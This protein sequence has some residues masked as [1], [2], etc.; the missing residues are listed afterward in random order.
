M[1]NEN[2]S[3][4]LTHV[5]SCLRDN[6]NHIQSSIGNSGDLIVKELL[7]MQKWPAAVFYIDGL[8]NTQLLHDSVLRS[9]M[10]M[11]TAESLTRSELP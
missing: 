5:S 7:W 1:Q 6:V 11:D 9:F 4:P 8:I 2:K 3:C 10:R